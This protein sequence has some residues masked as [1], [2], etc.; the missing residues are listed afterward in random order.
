M[1]DQAKLLAALDRA[2]SIWMFAYADQK[3]AAQDAATLT[4]LR[5]QI[6][7]NKPPPE[8]IDY[9]AKNYPPMT[10]IGEP[11]WH[12]PRIWRAAMHALTGAD[13]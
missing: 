4:T 6:A 10:I 13:Q 5:D 12:A 3:Q 9:M 1:S 7:G 2:I 8:F 11:N